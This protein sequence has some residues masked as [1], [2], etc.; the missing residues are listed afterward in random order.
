MSFARLLTVLSIYRQYQETC[1]SSQ[2]VSELPRPRPQ[3]RPFWSART[4]VHYIQVSLWSNVR[5][6]ASTH[7]SPRALLHLLIDFFF[8]INHVTITE[9]GKW[10]RTILYER[11]ARDLRYGIDCHH[12]SEY[13]SPLKM[14]NMILK[15]QNRDNSTIT[16]IILTL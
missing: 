7:F 6:K 2:Q 3:R 4:Y 12:S 9:G 11:R 8:M 14:Y 16:F 1:K 10:P 13:L 5:E 15:F